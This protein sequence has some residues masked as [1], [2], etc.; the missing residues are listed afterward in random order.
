MP[1]AERVTTLLLPGL[2]NSGPEHWMTYWE[3]QDPTCHRVLQTEWDT[4]RCEDWVSKLNEAVA[5]LA[6]PAVLV[7]HSSACALVGH[8][9]VSAPSQHLHRIR[10]ALLVAPSD[11]EATAYP[12]GPT[13]F[14]PMPL[15][16]LPF[17]T[18]VVTSVNDVYVTPER[19]SDFARAWGSEL[20]EIGAAGHINSASGLRDWPQGYVLLQSLR[21]SAQ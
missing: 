8:W 3:R 18:I 15:M 7:A 19:A 11:T 4:P 6:H 13:G 5:E 1:T 9:V 14:A 16:R 17:R 12:M 2:S 10:G 21:G 20:V